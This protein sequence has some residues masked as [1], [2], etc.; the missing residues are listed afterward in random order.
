MPRAS[1]LIYST[2]SL[3]AWSA[4]LANAVAVS[5]VNGETQPGSYIVVL[6]E[7][8]SMKTHVASVKGKLATS[9]AK[10]KSQVTYDYDFMNGYS[11]ELDEDSLK[12]LTQSPDVEMIVP[13]SLV[14][15]DASTL[16]Q[17][18]A[19]W[20]L[21]RVSSK[22][23]LPEGSSASYYNY[24]FERKPSPAGVDVYVLDTGVNIH[25]TDFQ[26]RARWGKTFGTDGDNDLHGHG[27]HVAGTVAG[28]RWGVA[29]A[30]SIIAVKVLSDK[31]PGKTSD[32]IAGVYW[33]V[34][35]ARRLRRPSVIN[36]SLGGSA[37]SA[38]DLA[39]NRAVA[40]G[41]HVV[42]S[43]GN[44]NV[45]AGNQSPARAES[46]ITVGAS[47]IADERWVSSNSSGSNFGKSVDIFAPGH[48]IMS[49][50]TNSTMNAVAKTGTSMAA[51]HVAGLI[52]YLLATE[53]RRTPQ[54]MLAR[55]KHL[56]P[57]GVLK[58]I[59]SDTRNE[60]IWNGQ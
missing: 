53:G 20:G 24:T 12:D 42:V 2:L 36:M 1:S 52:A 59:P 6:K 51:P 46:V 39:C 54:N 56:A 30:A 17:N 26:G 14:Y 15:P 38:L 7:T 22:V 47:N 57:D 40:A 25:H 4:S 44:K 9:K 8:A 11:A 23:K 43:A 31:G 18:D 10:T 34:A 50:A 60:I 41:V 49:A 32:I 37:N 29:K 5:Q 58:G 16:V 3:I 19:P 28:K 33:A 55:V 21:S 48:R 27:T 45:D 13:D 35:E